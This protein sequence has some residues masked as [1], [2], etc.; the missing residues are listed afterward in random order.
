M[1]NKSIWIYLK[2]LFFELDVIG[3]I[4]ITAGFALVLLAIT[5][6]GYQKEKVERSKYYC[7]VGNRILLSCGGLCVGIQVC[8]FPTAAMESHP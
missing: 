6:A 7:D 1:R 5:L 4:L 8:S 3:V 2:E